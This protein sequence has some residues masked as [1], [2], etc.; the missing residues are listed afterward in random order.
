MRTGLTVTLAA[1]VVAIAALAYGLSGQVSSAPRSSPTPGS[2]APCPNQAERCAGQTPPASSASAASPSRSASASAHKM[3]VIVEENHSSAQAIASMPHLATWAARFGQ[4]SNYTAVAHPS[5]P[6]YLAVGGGSTF[7]VSDDDEPAAHPINGRSVFGQTL[8][9]GKT[10]AAYAESMPSTC[11]LTSSGDYAVKHNEWA[12]F[13]DASERAACVAHDVPM[14]TTAGGA[15]LRDVTS[16][17]LPVTGQM[18]PDICNDAHDCS[19]ATADAWLNTWIRV[20]L[21]GPDY[22]S[23]R[24]TIVITFDEDDHSANNNVALVV[25]DPRLRGV[26]VR[27]AADHYSLTRWLET[28]AGVALLARAATATDL[29]SAFGL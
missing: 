19:L 3:M 28:N 4:A 5:L 8:A 20:L 7:G 2:G 25:I 13:A 29:K 12:Y 27:S 1:L 21:D 10:A 22:R 24:L 14:G 18:T 23:G 16:G 9:A 26:T 6:N 17:R 11:D 15:L